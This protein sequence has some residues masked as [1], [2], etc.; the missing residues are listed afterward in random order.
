VCRSLPPQGMKYT[1]LSVRSQARLPFGRGV[2]CE[3]G[4]L[5]AAVI[6]A[7]A[8]IHSANLGKCAVHGLDSRFRGNDR[9]FVRDEIPNDTTTFFSV[10]GQFGTVA[11]IPQGGIAKWWLRREQGV[12]DRRQSRRNNKVPCS[13]PR[14]RPAIIA[15]WPT[16]GMVRINT[17]GDPETRCRRLGRATPSSRN[18]GFS[19]TTSP[20][21]SG[22]Q[23]KRYCPAAVILGDRSTSKL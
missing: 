15:F 12:Q 8:G 11:A 1:R 6:P 9:G 5:Q 23:R 18:C 10:V 3:T 21:P 20:P 13:A 19:T 14:T 7:K 4:A 2:I 16:P 22:T 17:S